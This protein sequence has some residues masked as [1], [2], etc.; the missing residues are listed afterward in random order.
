MPML[1]EIDG[2][3]RARTW[4]GNRVTVT[5]PG[6]YTLSVDGVEGYKPIADRK[7][8]IRPAEWTKVEIQLARIR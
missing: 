2:K 3:G 4:S 6:Q 8:T 1:K 5:G 7:V